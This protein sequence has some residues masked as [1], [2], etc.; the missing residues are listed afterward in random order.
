V[1]RPHDPTKA[2]NNRRVFHVNGWCRKRRFTF[3]QV[4]FNTAR[5]PHYLLAILACVA[6]FSC[7]K[8]A[9]LASPAGL[10]FSTDTL[11]FDTV[12]T[13]AGSFTLGLKMYNPTGSAVE[14]S[15]VRVAGGAASPFKINVDGRPGPGVDRV[16][17]EA[18]DSVYIFA[19]VNIDPTAADAPFVVT[20]SLLATVAGGEQRVVLQA[21]GQNANY[22]IG[23]ELTG[24]NTWAPNKPWVVVNSALVAP[25]AT[26]NIL[27]GTRVYMHANSRLLVQGTLRAIGTKT[28]SIIF[29]GDRLDRAYFA[30]EGFPGEWGGLYFDTASTNNLLTHVIL[31][32]G[33]NNALGAV[34]AL[35]Q[36][37]PDRVTDAAPQLTLDRCVV[38]YSLG[39][40]LLSFGGTVRA[41]NCLFQAC[42]AQALAVLEGGADTFNH[43]TFALYPKSTVGGIVK[44]SHTDNPAVALLNFFDISETAFRSADL[45]AVLRNCIIWGTLEDEIICGRKGSAAYDVRLE[46]CILKTTDPDATSAATLDAQT[47]ALKNADP[48]F[49]DPE[50]D[51]DFRLAAGSAARGAAI[52][53]AGILTD[54]DDNPRT[55]PA[56]IGCY[57][58]N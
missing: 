58:A 4:P 28:D 53:L 31:R 1:R 49:E 18:R 35:I 19:T 54:L 33:G 6:L 7:R 34:P 22:I 24:V 47:T 13:A 9:D 27:P 8:D 29:Q 26:L 55:A 40:G 17:I 25:G 12:F 36:V 3:N 46:H 2:P 41:D 52:F 20:D 50:R 51:D 32:N 57:E 11:T 39:Y 10:R 5:S 30:N 44:L 45:G 38:E 21:W 48:Q 16:R 14:V 37:N 43:C 56:D 15:N 42:G 23:Q